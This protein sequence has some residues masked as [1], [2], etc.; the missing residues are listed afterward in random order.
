[1][2][3]LGVP[4]DD[5]TLANG[6]IYAEKDAQKIYEGLLSQDPSLTEI[7]DKEIIA[8]IAYLQSMG[9]RTISGNGQEVSKSN[10]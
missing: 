5:D 1:M 6:D 7:K 4:Y 2:K 8:L 10:R 9:K 3:R